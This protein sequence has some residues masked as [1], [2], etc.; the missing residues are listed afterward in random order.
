MRWD[1]GRGRKGYVRSLL[2]HRIV[3]L[4]LYPMRTC[5]S[6]TRREHLETEESPECLEEG[7]RARH[8]VRSPGTDEALEAVVAFL[9]ESETGV[10]Q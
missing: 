4:P 6:C 8:P 7:G 9:S 3:Q 1:R 5:T 2:E 10:S